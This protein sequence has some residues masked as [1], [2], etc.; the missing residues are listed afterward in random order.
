SSSKSRGFSPATVVS[1]GPGRMAMARSART[2]AAVSLTRHTSTCWPVSGLV[3]VAGSRLTPLMRPRNPTTSSG[4]RRMR[5]GRPMRAGGGARQAPRAALSAPDPL[6][7]DDGQ[8]EVGGC[9][10]RVQVGSVPVDL[11]VVE[12]DQVGA[13]P[14]GGDDLVADRD[15]GGVEGAHAVAPSAV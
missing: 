15:G 2:S 6:G 1:P 14:A 13:G 8:G 9:G 11:Q 7:V 4:S 5:T 3:T 10:R 12:G